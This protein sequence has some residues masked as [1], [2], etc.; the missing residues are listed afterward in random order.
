MFETYKLMQKVNTTLLKEKTLEEVVFLFQTTADGRVKNKCFAYIFC[1]LFPM[2]LKIHKKYVNFNHEEKTEVVITCLERSIQRYK[3][4]TKTKFSTFLYGNIVNGFIS[5]YERLN[6]N[7]N[8]VWLN[9]QRT[10]DNTN[11]LS[12]VKY[13][14]NNLRYNMFVNDLKTIMEPEELSLCKLLMAGY[15]NKKDLYN[16]SYKMLS[17]SQAYSKINKLKQNI[18]KKI[19]QN[20]ELFI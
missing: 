9:I 12:K 13:V 5:Y 10:T 14:D 6:R 7:K 16:A 2:L 18:K 17:E 1:E 19:Q 8:K 15:K 3:I 4:N 11:P 20:K